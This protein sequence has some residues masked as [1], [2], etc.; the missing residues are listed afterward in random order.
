MSSSVPTPTSS[1]LAAGASASGAAG[2][3]ASA[4]A[5]AAAALIHGATRDEGSLYGGLIPSHQANLAGVIL[6]AIAWAYHTVMGLYYKQW[7]FL[8]TW[9]IGCGLETAGYVGRFCSSTDLTNINDFLVQIIC[10]TLAPA[11]LMGGV[12]YLLAKLAMV[13]GPQFSPLKP[14]HYSLIFILCDLVSIVIQ[15]AGGGLAAVAVQNG[16]N[17]QPGTHVM[18]AGM[19]FQVFSVVLFIGFFSHFMWQI[20]RNRRSAEF[21]PEYSA[22]RATR[23]FKL[24]PWAIAWCVICVFIRSVYR[25]CEL[26]EGWTG[27]LI[28]TERYFLVL[29]GL[30][31]FLGVLG[32]SIVYPGFALGREVIAV[33]GF[34]WNIKTKPSPFEKNVSESSLEG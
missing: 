23:A 30:F 27:Y 21:N 24:L 28:V 13:Y 16:E 26:S 33:K 12:Y 15:A 1:L 20:Y 6:F 11:F 31:I 18:V 7:W 14:M 5:G 8:V 32:L 9:F 19:A 3:S 2:A 25:I 17:T 4:I 10:L 34:H 29:D 22:L